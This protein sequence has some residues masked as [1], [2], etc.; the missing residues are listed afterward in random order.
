M[1]ITDPSWIYELVRELVEY[2][3]PSRKLDPDRERVAVECL[4]FSG[5]KGLKKF[6]DKE[7]G[8]AISV[9]PVADLPT[10]RT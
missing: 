6:L 2:E 9:G 4:R 3:Y 1:I 10:A 7:L 8:P 5:G